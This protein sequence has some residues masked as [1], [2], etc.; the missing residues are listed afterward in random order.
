[1][2]QPTAAEIPNV[3]GAHHLGDLGRGGVTWKVYLETN[4]SSVPVRARVHFVSDTAQR[5]TGWIFIERTEQD[6]LQRFHEFSALELW[7]VLE[8]LA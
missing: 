8:S 6:L 5:S 7:R 4:T 1:M 2:T 3:S